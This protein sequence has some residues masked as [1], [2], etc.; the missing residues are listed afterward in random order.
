MIEFVYFDIG[1]TLLKDEMSHEQAFHYALD[2]AGFAFTLE[3]VRR[4]CR[5][6]HE[7]LCRGFLDGSLVERDGPKVWNRALYEA[8]GIETDA[9]LVDLMI[10]R[11]LGSLAWGMVDEEAVEVLEALRQRG[12]RLG[13]LSNWGD[14]LARHLR[15]KDLA[16]YFD[17]IVAS[18]AEG[19]SKPHPDL[20]RIALER[21]GTAP[22]RTAHVGDRVCYD[23]APAR[24]AGMV[25]VLIDRWGFE[26]PYDGPRIQR[27]SELPRALFGDAPVEDSA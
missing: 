20:F 3:A 2:Q 15:E 24:A 19:V 8:L 27:M 7:A 9:D 23:T 5:R 26:P 14:G 10:E 1:G 6:A 21:A 11:L 4:A 17:V 12:V 18:G 16:G 22:E 13:V 25:G